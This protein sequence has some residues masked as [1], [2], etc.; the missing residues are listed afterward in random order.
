M[1]YK[2][3]Y[4][5]NLFYFDQKHF[6]HYQSKYSGFNLG[7]DKLKLQ[8]K[9]T[10]YHCKISRLYKLQLT[11]PLDCLLVLYFHLDC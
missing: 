6:C 3:I 9:V 1:I 8:K 7:G 4:S 11:L 5:D 2:K 10:Q